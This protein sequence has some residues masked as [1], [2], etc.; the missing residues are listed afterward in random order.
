MKRKLFISYSHEDVKIVKQFALQL[1]LCGFDLWMDE[2]N[3]SFAL[4]IKHMMC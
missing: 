3:V 1:S 4:M 2:K